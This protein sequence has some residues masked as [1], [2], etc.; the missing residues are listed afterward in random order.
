[1]EDVTLAEALLALMSKSDAR[2][3]QV[4]GPGFTFRA[5]RRFSS[6]PPHT[7]LS[8]HNISGDMADVPVTPDD[9]ES[10]EPEIAEVDV[11]SHIVGLFRPLDTPITVGSVVNQGA[12]L[13]AIE[14]MHLLNEIDA[15][16]SGTITYVAVSPNAPVQYGDLLFR[17]RP[18]SSA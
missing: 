16:V 2:T 5:T 13:A 12:H 9:T 10:A 17:I 1:M 11:R 18:H 15:P 7:S 14:A 8:G 4:S 6:E 3:L